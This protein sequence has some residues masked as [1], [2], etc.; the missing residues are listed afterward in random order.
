MLGNIGKEIGKEVA[1]GLAKKATPKVVPAAKKPLKWGFKGRKE[2]D[3]QDLDYQHIEDELK[4]N[5]NL[6]KKT[7]KQYQD[8][9]DLN[10]DSL[11]QGAT[12][13]KKLKELVD[14]Q[15][16]SGDTLEIAN[17]YFRDLEKNYGVPR[18]LTGRILVSKFNRPYFDLFVPPSEKANYT[19]K[20]TNT[21]KKNWL[22]Y[23]NDLTPVQKE[24]FDALESGWEGTM[25]ELLEA[26]KRLA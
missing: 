20:T 17:Y 23:Y 25:S 2:T 1:E 8:D 22:S 9:L 6:K 4:F 13:N 26:V 11:V 5:P 18:E 21:W 24:T 15:L 16:T 14:K 19:K 10:W 12:K 7:L 3:I